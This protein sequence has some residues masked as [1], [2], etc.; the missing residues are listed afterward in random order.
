MSSKLDLL[1]TS[2]VFPYKPIPLYLSDRFLEFSI[3]D[4]AFK[5][6][7]KIGLTCVLSPAITQ[8]LTKC[9]LPRPVTWGHSP[10]GS[11]PTLKIRLSG[12]CRRGRIPQPHHTSSCLPTIDSRAMVIITILYFDHPCPLYEFPLRLR[13]EGRPTLE[14]SASTCHLQILHYSR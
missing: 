1:E 11:P 13:A 14:V 9:L 10:S 12:P 2:L 3:S 4:L 7:Y 6:F 5:S 8:S